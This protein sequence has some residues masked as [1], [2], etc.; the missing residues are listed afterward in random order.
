MK[1][2]RKLV[3]AK[4]IIAFGLG[5][6]IVSTI[7]YSLWI[8]VKQIAPNPSW[9][10]HPASAK[11]PIIDPEN[12]RGDQDKKAN[13]DN[14]VIKNI[15]PDVHQSKSQTASDDGHNSPLTPDSVGNK[16][17]KQQL[18]LA[19]K[20]FHIRLGD[21]VLS[22]TTEIRGPYRQKVRRIRTRDYNSLIFDY[23]TGQLLSY[24]T[25][26]PPDAPSGLTW[27]DAIPKEDALR[28]ARDILKT[29]GVSLEINLA[30]IHLQ[31]GE[32]VQDRDLLG[33][34]WAVIARYTY[35]GVPFVDSAIQITIS[36]FSGDVTSFSNKPIREIPENM[37]L[38]FEQD[39]AKEQTI[40]FLRTKI[41]DQLVLQ[42]DSM[43]R[44]MIAYP[45]NFWTRADT[46]E[47]QRAEKPKQCWVLDVLLATDGD[48][49]QVY[50]DAQTGEVVG[51]MG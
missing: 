16:L 21:N 49:I 25:A 36:A 11:E 41:S 7:G 19:L 47:L 40:E 10:S 50:V 37:Q 31:D 35:E 45:N 17:F 23:H 24:F 8:E 15:T 28:R 34:E 39:K 32:S 26:V 51:G 44:R 6:I 9:Q 12:K 14:L 33:T 30:D 20:T 18:E 29:F 5:A 38:N 13:D 43:P 42:P 48:P 3:F 46:E 27:D 22:D 1:R 4:F 2:A